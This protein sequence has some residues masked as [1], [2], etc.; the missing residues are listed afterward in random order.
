MAA[1]AAGVIALLVVRFGASAA[2]PWL[3]PVLT[4]L[5]AA[6][7]AFGAVRMID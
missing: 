6:A 1:I 7:V 3:D 2:Y 5:V 4:G